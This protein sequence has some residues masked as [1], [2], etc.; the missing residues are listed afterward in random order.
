MT[1]PETAK[2]VQE[3]APFLEKH[4]DFQ[5]V[6]Y[7]TDLEEIRRLSKKL[8]EVLKS[9]KL[10]F[11]RHETIQIAKSVFDYAAQKELYQQSPQLFYDFRCGDARIAITRKYKNGKQ[12]YFITVLGYRP[13][14]MCKVKTNEFGWGLAETIDGVLEDFYELIYDFTL[15]HSNILF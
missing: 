4:A 10:R 3:V 11:D 8:E 15:N 12:N 13:S 9:M 5:N 14:N 1:S 6:F 7:D 2:E